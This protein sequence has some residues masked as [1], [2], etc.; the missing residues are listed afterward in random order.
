M[1][2]RTI[3]DC[4][5]VLVFPVNVIIVINRQPL[6]AD[7]LAVRLFLEKILDTYILEPGIDV[8]VGIVGDD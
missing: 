8:V 3:I 4:K 6:G 7:E 1:R 5:N 2:D